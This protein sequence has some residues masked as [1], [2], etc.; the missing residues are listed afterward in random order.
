MIDLFPLGRLVQK[1]GTKIK[2]VYYL[3]EYKFGSKPIPDSKKDRFGGWND[4]SAVKYT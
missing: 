1:T 4:G 3:L 2:E